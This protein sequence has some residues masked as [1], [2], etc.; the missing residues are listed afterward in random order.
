VLLCLGLAGCAGF[1]PDGGFGPVQQAA[2]DRLGQE[3]H[4]ARTD[5]DRQALQQRT[6]ELLA[7]PLTADSAVQVALLNHRGLQAGFQQLGIAEAEVVAASRLPNP[8]FS[9]GRLRRGDEREIERGL[10][11]DLGHL[12]TLPLRRPLEQR[13]F[14]AAQR[15]VAMSVFTLATDTRKAFYQAVAAEQAVRYQQDVAA[16]AE[17][18]AELAR[19]MAAAGNWSALQQAREQAFQADAAL[20]VARARG[21]QVRARE[22]LVRL[23]GLDSASFTLPDR[24]PDLP[25]TPAPQADIEQRAID[26]RLDVQAARLQAEA[27]AKN[28][29]LSRVTRWV[30]VLEFG[31]QRNT[32]NLDTPQTGYEISL[33]LP[34]F[35][36]SGARTVQAEALYRQSLNRAAQTGID[37]RSQVREAWAAMAAAHEVARRYRDE[38]V[39]SNQRISEQ[40]LL[41]YNGMLIGVFELLADARAQIASVNASIQAQRD[42]WLAQADLDMALIGPPSFSPAGTAAPSSVAAPA[43]GH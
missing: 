15:Q 41:R 30:N 43:D 16:A 7:R 3:V 11:F 10:S 6:R 35:D 33:E 8:G 40:N 29:G 4:W 18:S 32:S 20:A 31:A 24:L 28:L 17:A 27:T 23:L 36:W 25:T 5:D 42:Y 37:A 13:R 34:L 14:E 21:E 39:P 19:R 26:Q 12:I 22:R 1:S 2:K 38:I 9:I